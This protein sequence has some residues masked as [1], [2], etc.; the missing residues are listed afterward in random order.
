MNGPDSPVAAEKPPAAAPAPPNIKAIVFRTLRRLGPTG[1]LAIIAT[2]LPI[3]GE[4][5]LLFLLRLIAPWLK[6]HGLVGVVLYAT[7][8]AATSGLAILPT[9]VQSILGG[10]AF[11]FALGFPAAVAG[12]LGGALLGYVVARRASG[13][14]VMTLIREQPKWA[15]IHRTLVGGGF[16]KSLLVV[17]LLR[18]AVTPFALTNLVLASVRIRLPVYILGAVL[19]LAPRTGAVVFLAAGVKEL[20]LGNLEHRWLWISSLAI[21]LLALFI[22]AHMANKAIERVTADA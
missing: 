11:G 22:I 19:G 16:G 12:V 9:H 21:T 6:S 20:T 2:T 18:L 15:A 14:R 10:W 13:D 7:G 8:F 1:P 4:V 17:T 5:T 3:I